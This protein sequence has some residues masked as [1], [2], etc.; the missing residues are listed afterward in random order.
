MLALRSTIGVRV[1]PEIE[2]SGLDLAEHA[3]Q[4]YHA[5]TTVGRSEPFGA[6]VREVVS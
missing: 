2:A 6:V 5:D 3:E 4:A 1:A